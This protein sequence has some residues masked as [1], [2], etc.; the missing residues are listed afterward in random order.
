MFVIVHRYGD[1]FIR[2]VGQICV[3]DTVDLSCEVVDSNVLED[4]GIHIVSRTR[5]FGILLAALGSRQRRRIALDVDSVVLDGH[6]FRFNYSG[7]LF[8]VNDKTIDLDTGN[9]EIYGAELAYPF[10]FGDMYVMRF[11]MSLTVTNSV[12]CFVTAVADSNGRLLVLYGRNMTSVSG[13]KSLALK[14]DLLSEV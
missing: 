11:R 12:T 7:S 1:R 9:Y 10:I 4:A 2:R 6:C 3:F 8:A 5:S 13:D 14:V